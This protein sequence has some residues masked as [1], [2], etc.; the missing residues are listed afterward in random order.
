MFVPNE[1]PDRDALI[2]LAKEDPEGFVDL[3]LAL[4]DRCEMLEKRVSEL[5]R[6][7]RN[8]SKPPSSDR[9][10]MSGSPKP[11]PKSQ[12]KGSK[13][14]RGGQPG[15]KGNTLK[16]VENPDHI[17]EHTLDSK[18]GCAKC[19]ELLFANANSHITCEPEIRQM[20]ELPAI[21]LEVTEHRAE[22]VICGV[23]ETPNT[24]DFPEGVNAPTQYGPNLRATAI[25]FGSYQLIPYR[26]LG[27]IFGD[28]FD[29]PISEGTLANFVKEGGRQAARAVAAIRSQIKASDSIYC[30][31]TGC[32]LH[33]KRNWLH[34]ASTKVLTCFM[35]HAKRG[36]EALEDMGLL[37]DYQGK[38][39]H[40]FWSSYYRYGQCQHFLCNAHLLRDLTYL[41]EE[42]D[43]AWAKDM[44]EL[45]LEAKELRDREN[46]RPPDRRRVIGE[47]TRDRIQ[48]RYMEIVLEGYADNPE[49]KPVPGKRGKPARGKTLNLLSRLENRY[50]EI[51]GFFEYD[52]VPFDNNQA[53]RDLRMMKTREK[54]SGTFRSDEHAAAFCNIRSVISTLKKQSLSVMEGI[55]EM[56][57][58]PDQMFTASPGGAE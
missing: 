51:M 35:I 11:K 12:R 18:R 9:G 6:N 45:L 55:G 49:P 16:Q 20:M 56:L 57:Q 5:E 26:R 15:H 7:S 37:R 47:K 22:R 53:E 17:V 50:E 21:R 33:G 36:F 28:L 29:C 58:N 13:R 4:W 1:R 41:H 10:N 39:I 48:S 32:R 8:S 30:D 52:D 34:V 31:E 38:I 42:M 27:E 19:G 24:A 54:I 44:I 3:F 40:D 46:D 25:Y 2:E 43:Q 14:K 23:C